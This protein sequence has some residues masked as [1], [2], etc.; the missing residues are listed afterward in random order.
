MGRAVSFFKATAEIFEKAKP[1]V[2]TIPSNYQD[3]FNNKYADIVKLRDKAIKD[4]KSIYFE[5]ELPMEQVPVPDSQNFV[6]L[7]PA[8]DNIQAKLPIEDKLRHIVPPEVRAMQ[9]ELKNQLQD[10]INQQYELENKNEADLR[11]FLSTYGLP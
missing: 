3:N 9:N 7:E 11:K 4:N 6:K 1:T 8:L 10:I 5:R 2:L